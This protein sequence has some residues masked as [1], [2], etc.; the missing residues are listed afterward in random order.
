[1]TVVRGSFRVGRLTVT[2][3][4]DGVSQAPR[5][6]QWF[7]GVPPEEWM[8]V[9]GV[10]DVDAE[11]TVNFGGFVITGDGS[12]TLVD[13]GIGQMATPQA[14]G[15]QPAMAGGGG[16]L[17]QLAEVGIAVQDVDRVVQTHLHGDHCGWLIGG[18]GGPDVVT[19]PNAEVF[20]SRPEV[21]Y[22]QSP[23]AEKNILPEVSRARID[24]VGAAGQLVQFDGERELSPEIRILPAPGHTP[25]H[26]VVMV[27]SEGE[28]ALLLGDVVHHCVHFERH[29]WLQSL[30]VD[31]PTSVATREAIVALAADRGSIVTATHMPILTLGRM[32]RTDTGIRY[33]PEPADSPVFVGDEHRV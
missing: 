10:D 14:A 18:D 22:W 12:V 25:G 19:F 17:Q 24:A 9:V 32:R 16:L 23:D 4:S 15:Q 31:P 3:V 5:G 20:I 1:M 2:A 28:S 26:V 29:S 11:F 27:E 6:P 33:E 7:T 13:C 21:E 30:D 8:P